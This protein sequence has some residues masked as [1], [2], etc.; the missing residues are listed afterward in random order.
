MP[1]TQIQG[2]QDLA[3]LQ[4]KID[5]PVNLSSD[6][7]LAFEARQED[8]GWGRACAHWIPFYG[9]YYAMQ[10]RT[11]TPYALGFGG[12]LV[13]GFILSFLVALSNPQVTEKELQ[14]LGTLSLL[15]MPVWVK[16]GIDSSRKQGAKK[17]EE[18]RS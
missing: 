5:A 17:L 10:R 16:M 15:T 9:L 11:I 13:T 14:S 4:V 1:Y 6:L 7:R 3:D 2:D 12:H 18:A 8:T